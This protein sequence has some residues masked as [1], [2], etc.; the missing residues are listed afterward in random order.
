MGSKT[1]ENVCVCVYICPIQFFR[2]FRNHENLSQ[3]VNKSP[4]CFTIICIYMTFPYYV[5][6]ISTPPNLSHYI[7]NKSDS[8]R[9]K[10]VKSKNIYWK[11]ASLLWQYTRRQ[12][13]KLFF[14]FFFSFFL[15]SFSLFAL[16][17][18]PLYPSIHQPIYKTFTF[19]FNYLWYSL[20]YTH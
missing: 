12:E 18:H 13:K 4:Y 15:S 5:Y 17:H 2:N 11:E 3:K 19:F 10:K 8:S 16:S 14:S 7:N 20:H 1:Y 9:K 6:I